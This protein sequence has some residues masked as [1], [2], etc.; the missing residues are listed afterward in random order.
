MQAGAAPLLQRVSGARQER[1]GQGPRPGAQN[2]RPEGR[3]GWT[4]GRAGPG[5]P[6][7]G[8]AVGLHV[9]RQHLSIF[10]TPQA[11]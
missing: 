1:D 2:P 6:E 4:A 8:A 11:H 5:L 7:G 9:E 3:G 10:L